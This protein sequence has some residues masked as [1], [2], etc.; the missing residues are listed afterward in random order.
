MT[1]VVR[2]LQRFSNANA[3]LAVN[4]NRNAVRFASQNLSWDFEVAE[5]HCRAFAMGLRSL[6]FAKGTRHATQAATF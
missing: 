6:N 4:K 2:A 3:Q 1:L 5:Y